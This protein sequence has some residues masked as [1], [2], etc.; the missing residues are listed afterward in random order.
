MSNLFDKGLMSPSR[1][2]RLY[3][4]AR[5]LFKADD[6]VLDTMKEEGRGLR[7]VCL[8]AGWVKRRMYD[9]P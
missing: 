5:G 6:D 2:C 9:V 3:P 8:V 4:F 7:S 1:L